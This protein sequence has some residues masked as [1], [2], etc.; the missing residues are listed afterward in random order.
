MGKAKPIRTEKV[1]EDT[2]PAAEPATAEPAGGE[3][4]AAHGLA[5][6]AEVPAPEDGPAEEPAAP[7]NREA[8]L[9]AELATLKDQ[10]LRALAETE[11]LRRRS[12]R[13][14]D[15]TAKYA[16]AGFARDLLSPVDNL[17]RALESVPAD[18]DRDNE[19]LATLLSGVELTERELL[20]AFEKH[21]LRKIEP[22][23]VPFDHNVHQAMFEVEDTGK[24]AGTV[25]QLLQAGYMLHDRLLRPAMV[26]VAKGEPDESTHQPVD[27]TA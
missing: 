11:N 1:D 20:Q 3:A 23:D 14:R 24:P 13:D 7:P 9:A 8:E 19:A 18:A 12:A 21:G 22:M 16:M 5:P 10:L 26:G 6:T 17:R 15:E 4:E 2:A 27:T 25:V